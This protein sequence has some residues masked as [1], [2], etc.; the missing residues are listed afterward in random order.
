M[1]RC[2]W[3]RGA[4]LGN[5]HNP[6][7]VTPWRGIRGATGCSWNGDN[8]LALRTASACIVIC[9]STANENWEVPKVSSKWRCSFQILKHKENTLD[10][11]VNLTLRSQLVLFFGGGRGGAKFVSFSNKEKR[12]YFIYY[13]L[14]KAIAIFKRKRKIVLLVTIKISS[15][16]RKN[17][18]KSTAFPKRKITKGNLRFII[19]KYLKPT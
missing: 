3:Q 2:C 5:I 4:S 19:T 14:I 16:L 15:F 18:S 12:N 10:R 11:I 13:F 7:A 17:F 1:T 9:R 6:G 8:G